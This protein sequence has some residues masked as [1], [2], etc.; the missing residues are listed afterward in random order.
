MS[1]YLSKSPNTLFKTVNSTFAKAFLYNVQSNNFNKKWL[2]KNINYSEYVTKA[3]EN[4]LQG[5]K[6]KIYII[7]NVDDKKIYLDEFLHKELIVKRKD[8]IP[9][10]YLYE[11]Q[12]ENNKIRIMVESQPNIFHQLDF[13]MCKTTAN[14]DDDESGND[15][16]NG[17]FKFHRKNV[18]STFYTQKNGKTVNNRLI[19]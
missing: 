7:W 9:Q 17:S 18:G 11:Q 8:N 13:E 4:I 6:N 15:Y 16:R 14:D 2:I 1:N 10:V 3:I 19:Q 12:L 5:Q